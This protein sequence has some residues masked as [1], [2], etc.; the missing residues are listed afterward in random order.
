MTA[1]NVEARLLALGRYIKRENKKLLAAK[2]PVRLSGV[3]PALHKILL[4]NFR[5]W[6][7]AK[8]FCVALSS[9]IS[10]MIL[11][12]RVQAIATVF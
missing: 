12:S 11:H 4:T 10:V 9:M 3:T 6:P 5:L 7:Y 1:R 8:L 2:N